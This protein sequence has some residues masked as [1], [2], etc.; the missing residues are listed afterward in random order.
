MVYLQTD[1]KHLSM[2]MIEIL[3]KLDNTSKIKS[4]IKCSPNN[5]FLDDFNW[6]IN[7]LLNLEIIEEKIKDKNMREYLVC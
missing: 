3:S 7:D 6:P 1:I 5:E 2:Q 4:S